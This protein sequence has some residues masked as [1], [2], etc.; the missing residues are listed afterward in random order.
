MNQDERNDPTWKLLGNASQKLP[1][2]SFT[3]DLVRSVRLE[4]EEPQLSRW[5]L[6]VQRLTTPIWKP[7]LGIATAACA[8]A[9]IA[10]PSLP[11]PVSPNG[12]GQVVEQSTNGEFE[13]DSSIV[14]VTAPLDE[15]SYRNELLASASRPSELDDEDMLELL[16]L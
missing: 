4:Q 7:A 6:L 11:D 15:L 16:I 3:Q 1:S 10:S 14:S 12:P 2:G 13:Q 8:I 9:F 5:Q